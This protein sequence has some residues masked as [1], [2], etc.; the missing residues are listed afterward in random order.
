MC[1]AGM[2]LKAMQD[3]LG[4]S[5]AETTLNIYTEATREFKHSEVERLADFFNENENT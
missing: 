1:E 4:H 2:N 5:D 3:I